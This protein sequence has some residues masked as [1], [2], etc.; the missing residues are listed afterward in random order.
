ML[1][2]GMDCFAPAWSRGR[3]YVACPH[4]IDA[5]LLIRFCTSTLS[6]VYAHRNITRVP[7]S[8]QRTLAQN[9]DNSFLFHEQY[10]VG[11]WVQVR[12]GFFRGDV[13]RVYMNSSESDEVY[14]QVVLRFVD[15]TLDKNASRKRC[16]RPPRQLFSVE[17]TT[18]QWEMLK[19]TGPIP[20]TYC[21]WSNVYFMN[22]L[23]L[24]RVQGIHYIEHYRPTLHDI[25]PYTI[26]KV[27][28]LKETNEELLRVG[29][30]IRGVKGGGLSDIDGVVISKSEEAVRVK[31]LHH[32][33]SEEKEIILGLGDVQRVFVEGDV[34]EVCVG[35]LRGRRGFVLDV[36]DERQLTF[37]D[38]C[39][40]QQVSKPH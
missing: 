32:S 7:D 19:D 22:G 35:E 31:I 30:H 20:G 10:P 12:Q 37:L 13:A 36:P 23:Q 24:L 26:A 11:S 40:K 33:D 6:C 38:T 18:Y 8:D 5:P 21:L 4:G 15:K 28:T 14:L 25:L 9:K 39:T 16:D 17:H 2:P 1:P 27:D 34:I 3:I 29:D